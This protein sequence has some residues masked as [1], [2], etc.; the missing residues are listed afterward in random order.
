[1]APD[2]R[3]A[4]RLLTAR[5]MFDPPFRPVYNQGVSE[6]PVGCAL[7]GHV[8]SVSTASVQRPAEPGGLGTRFAFRDLGEQRWVRLSEGV[9]LL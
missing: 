7:F 5:R 9:R 4:T 2:R 8:E 1:M 3:T 6:L